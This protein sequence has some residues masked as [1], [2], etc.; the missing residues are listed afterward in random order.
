MN[1]GL[2]AAP[3]EMTLFVPT[4]AGYR[5][6]GLASLNREEAEGWLSEKTLVGFRREHLRI[7][8]RTISL[9]ALD[10]FGVSPAFVKIDVQGAEAEVLAGS[11][12]TLG[13]HHPVLI[14]EAALDSEP[15]RILSSLGY[16]AFAFARGR[17]TPRTVST[18]NGVFVHPQG[19]RGLD[20][21]ISR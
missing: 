2:A 9:A 20:R 10:S 4:Y 21:L 17:L 12:E 14:V 8:E 15:S 18:R 19:V 13:R 5:F 3:A 11:R 1:V 7:E 16:E 6:D